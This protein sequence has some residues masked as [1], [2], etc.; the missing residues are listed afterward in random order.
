MGLFSKKKVEEKQ[1][2]PPL[3]F[4]E[5]PKPKDQ[6][7]FESMNPS[8]QG[9]IKRTI[10]PP[11]NLMIPIRKPVQQKSEELMEERTPMRMEERPRPRM[12]EYSRPQ[13]REKTLFIKVDKYRAILAKMDEIKGKI[14]ES[15][16]ILQKLQDIRSQEEHELKL[17]QDDL[18]RVKDNLIAI[19][20]TL[21]E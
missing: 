19:D 20:R 10:M 12:E 11:P 4:P 5:F 8:D 16:R 2:L 7:H 21:F 15:D 17:W 13:Q 3:K 1:E 9:I 18:N 14:A 6:P